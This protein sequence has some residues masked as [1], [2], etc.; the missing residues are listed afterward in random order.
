MQTRQPYGYR[1]VPALTAPRAVP[2]GPHR[3]PEPSPTGP[4]IARGG[5]SGGPSDPTPEDEAAR[6][7]PVRA[8]VVEEF[9]R[10]CRRRRRVGWPEL[11][12]EMC[13]VASRGL[14]RGWTF[15]E[16]A[17][18][19]IGFTLADM[20]RLA[21]VV[22]EVVRAER[23]LA[24]GAA[25][26][27][28]AVTGSGRGSVPGAGARVARAEAAARRDLERGGP[29]GGAEHLSAF[30][31]AEDAAEPVREVRLPAAASA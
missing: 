22:D 28:V 4:T 5:S 15:V 6:R 12:D 3:R 29:P 25:D 13:A 26:G 10:F 23:A 30:E 1:H 7:E 20:P 16:L 8:G 27:L 18:Q 2:G 19:G 31:R 11:Y 21:A 17:E 24:A 14:F 9:V